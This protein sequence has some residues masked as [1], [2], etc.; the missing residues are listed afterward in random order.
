MSDGSP[1][2]TERELHRE[3]FER[4]PAEAVRLLETMPADAVANAL[5]SHPALVTRAV[6]E[7]LPNDLAG[8]T[9]AHLGVGAAGEVLGHMAPRKA[10]QIL[11]TYDEETRERM[12]TGIDRASAKSIR[13]LMNYPQGTAGAL[14]D[15]RTMGF[16]PNMTIGDAINRLR[17]S[18][19]RGM[20][21]GFIVDDAGRL[22]GLIEIQD[23]AFSPPETLTRTCCSPRT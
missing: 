9:L 11:L 16:R 20:R 2:A 3:L 19:R 8:E 6:W 22:Q 4:Y 21:V 17:A 23:L 10:A 15:L 12:M 13:S 1:I 7:L 5:D 14:M 18:E